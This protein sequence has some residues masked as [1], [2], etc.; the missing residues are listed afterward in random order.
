MLVG[1]SV[2]PETQGR[3]ARDTLGMQTRTLPAHGAAEKSVMLALDTASTKVLCL[4]PG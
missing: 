4:P 1:K 2:S 3:D